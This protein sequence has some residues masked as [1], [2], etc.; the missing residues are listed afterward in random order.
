MC[1]KIAVLC[2]LLVGA[3]LLTT[4]AR[5]ISPAAP[6]RAADSTE[7]QNTLSEAERAAGWRLLF[8]GKTA[9]GWRQ[10]RGKGLPE[11]WQV[12]DGTLVLHHEP[13]KSSGD[14]VTADQFGSFELSLEWKIAPGGNSG[15]MYHVTE[16]A[17]APWMTGPEYQLLD[18]AKHPDGRSRRTS[19]ASCY[20]LYAPVKDATRPVG[21]WNQTRIVVRGPHVEH[22][23]NG[24][25]V[26]TY[27]LGS[28]DW[29]KR[30][31]KSKF[32]DMPRF[33]KEPQGHIDLQD[34]GDDIA[35]RNIKI[36]E[37]EPNTLTEAEKAEGWK[38]LFDGKS[39][40]GWRRYRGKGM[41]QN[42]HVIDGTLALRH[43]RGKSGGDI[44][45]THEF[46]SFDLS[47]EWKIAS[48]GN[49]GVMYH[50][51][52]EEDQPGL[53]GPEY[54]LLDNA[55]HPDGRSLLTSAASCYGL[56]APVKDM[57]K[58]IGEW[59]LT[60]ILVNGNHVEHWLNGVKVVT[61]ELNSPDWKDR[62]AKSKFN[63]FPRFN[64]A[65]RG[66]IDLQDHGDDIAF[67]NVRI[68]VLKGEE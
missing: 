27:E 35:F 25:K 29:D 42:W 30:V 14:I 21:E 28:D 62:V 58:P 23:L 7:P 52:E 36:R 31:S 44:V 50:V 9:E 41:P 51:T 63:A 40:D 64:H 56:Y 46:A 65:S 4:G 2:T 33:G 61:Y 53:T 34:H 15:V 60:R 66:Y 17:D 38:L 18:N 10:Y 20:A 22:W 1:K 45:T 59:N 12:V 11:N 67:R 48:G 39:A 49:S 19:A 16:E 32:K 43:E 47:L 57:T 55:K 6:A 68:R 54:Q 26:V 3:Y 8:D 5:I 37:R 24:D 13:G